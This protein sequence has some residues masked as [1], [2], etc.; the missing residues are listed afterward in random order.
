MLSILPS[1]FAEPK[2][3]TVLLM[4]SPSAGVRSKSVGLCVSAVGLAFSSAVWGL[5]LL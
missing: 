5:L 3:W 1:S 4:P 2:S